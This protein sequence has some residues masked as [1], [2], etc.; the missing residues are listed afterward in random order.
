[1]VHVQ[2]RDANFSC[3]L[4]VCSDSAW[5]TYLSKFPGQQSSTTVRTYVLHI[6]VNNLLWTACVPTVWLSV[7]WCEMHGLL[8]EWWD[9]TQFSRRRLFICLHMYL[10][11]CVW[12]ML[13]Y[14]CMSSANVH[15]CM[16]THRRKFSEDAVAHVKH[17]QSAT[18]Q[19]VATKH[20]KGAFTSF[21]A[22][23]RLL[24]IS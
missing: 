22:L 13:N 2:C 17:R 7:L 5:F 10:S 6:M 15:A 16:R 20:N 9:A 3:L 24:H 11:Y 1:M 19:L 12:N 8:T 18:F 23:D 4:V 14:D 21:Y